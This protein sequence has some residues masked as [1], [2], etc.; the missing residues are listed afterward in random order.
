MVSM[1]IGP[2]FPYEITVLFRRSRSRRLCGFEEWYVTS[3]AEFYWHLTCYSCSAMMYG[4]TMSLKNEIVKLASFGRVNCIA[5]GWVNTVSVRSSCLTVV[6]LNRSPRQWRKTLSRIH[7]WHTPR[8][9][10]G[11]FCSPCLLGKCLDAD[12]YQKQD[13]IEKNRTAKRHRK[14][15]SCPGFE[16]SIWSCY[17]T[18]PYG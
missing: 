17:R 2:L 15:D 12:I 14:A 5:P 6:L 8:L 18:G 3:E 4:L 13:P 1:G 11:C 9:R 16:Q 7:A 10:R